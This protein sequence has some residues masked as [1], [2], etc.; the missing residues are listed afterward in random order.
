M[1]IAII[2]AGIVGAATAYEMGH[3]G[4]DVTVFEQ[5][6]APAEAASFA[7][8]GQLGPLQLLPWAHPS[9]TRPANLWDAQPTLRMRGLMSRQDLAWL[10]QWKQNAKNNH[11]A[12]D[13]AIGLAHYSSA[14]TQSIMDQQS[15]DFEN[16]RGRLVIFK[17]EQHQAQWQPIAQKIGEAG[18]AI[19]AVTPEMARQLEP[20]LSTNTPLAGGYHLPDALNGNSRLLSQILRQ[21]TQK[22]GV[23]WKFHT[24]VKRLSR[25]NV[26][27]YLNDDANMLPF[28][29]IILCTG[30]ASPALLRPLGLSLALTHLHGYCVTTSLREP[31]L[32]P[33][34]SLLDPQE[35][36]GITR[37]GNRIRV[38]GGA[39][40]GGNATTAHHAPTLQ[41]LYRFLQ[42][43]FPGGA[44]LTAEHQVWRGC[45]LMLPDG[46]PVFGKTH[47]Q[48]VWMNT[49]HGGAGLAL[50]FGSARIL[51]DL[52]GGKAPAIDPSPFSIDR[53]AKNRAC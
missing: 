22:M 51:T 2:G 34:A 49:G 31:A 42:E 27:L 18:I 19:H 14:C 24:P 3:A 8:G 29:H 45:R 12:S 17:S 11:P 13:A 37:L 53:L 26:G 33:K 5:H 48:G 52:V 1:K 35:Q 41:K 46:A 47:K 20:G 40:L 25:S 39:E 16:T 28:D 38:F 7:S 10:L 43:W 4:H 36:I 44:Q 50:A 30:A 6:G 15:A 23:Q 21:S 32:A 9:Y